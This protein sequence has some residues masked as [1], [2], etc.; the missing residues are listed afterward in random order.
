MNQVLEHDPVKTPAHYHAGNGLEV[1]DVIEAWGLGFHLGNAA[2][3]ILRAGHKGDPNEDLAKACRYLS[4]AAAVPELAVFPSH[5]APETTMLEPWHVARAFE[6]NWDC[7][8][9]VRKIYQAI[10][11]ESGPKAAQY[12]RDAKLALEREIGHAIDDWRVR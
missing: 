3:Y 7:T 2:K 11:T 10:R 5:F 8:Y 1:I 4:R 6:L 9:A 12:L